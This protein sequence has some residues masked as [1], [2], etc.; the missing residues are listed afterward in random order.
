MFYLQLKGAAMGKVFA[1]T[2]ANLTM[3][4]HDIQV[5]FIF[6]NTYNLIVSKFFEENSFRISNNSK[7]LLHTKLIKP[8]DIPNR[9][10][11]FTSNPLRSSLRT[12]SFCLATRIGC[13][14]E[15]ENTKLKRL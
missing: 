10:V 7:I 1:P 4:Y 11:L 2:Y 6:K 15:E 3:A 14:V 12:I 9:N 5:Y 13:I 8:A